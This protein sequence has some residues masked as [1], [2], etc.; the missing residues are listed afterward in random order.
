MKLQEEKREAIIPPVS[1]VG[2]ACSDGRSEWPALSRV[3]QMTGQELAPR[4]EWAQCRTSECSN[5]GHVHAHSQ[6]SEDTATES[7]RHSL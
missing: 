1:L 3:L 4:P 2:G 7:A 6:S 5:Q